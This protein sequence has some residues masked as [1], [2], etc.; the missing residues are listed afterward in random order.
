M[1][2]QVKKKPLHT[3]K[4]KSFSRRQKYLVDEGVNLN[5]W[6]VRAHTTAASLLVR[7]FGIS[8][9]HS[10]VDLERTLRPA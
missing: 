10:L 5:A 6:L 1:I 8:A 3:D 2:E 4:G 7:S 9:S